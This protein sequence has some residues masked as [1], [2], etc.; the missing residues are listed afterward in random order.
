MKIFKNRYSLIKEISKK[1]DISF[2]PT[3]GSIHRGHLSL[4][5]KAK[6]ESS[7]IL[8]SIYVNPK[9]F[10]SIADFKKYP[11]NLIKDIKLLKKKKI[12]YLYLPNKKD[13]F[14]LK[15]KIPTYLD[16]FSKKLC[17][18]FRPGHFKGVVDVVNRFLEII[19][20]KSIY[21]GIKD[22]QQLILIKSHIKKNKIKT[23]VVS[24]P[25]IRERTGIALSSRNIRLNKNQLKIAEEIYKF[26]KLNKKKIFIKN[27]NNKKLD[28]FNKIKKFGV[29]K[30]DY[31]ECLNITTLKKPQHIN[32]K[33]NL[34]IA[35]YIDK[36]RL[37]DNL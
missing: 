13:I 5:D 19:K 14:S 32:E 24:C 2:V 35:Y 34:F 33:F 12:R 25:V 18:K 1:K 28:I 29:K 16:K 21:L 7:N 8:V 27:L 3:M 4:I 11:R 9:Q 10:N 37:I 17:G 30:I 31:L 15:V 20:P 23:E 6:K 22:F 36:V 26:L